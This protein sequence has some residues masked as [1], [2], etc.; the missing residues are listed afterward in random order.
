MTHTLPGRYH[1]LAHPL[2]TSPS[3]PRDSP[4]LLPAVFQRFQGGGSKPDT[5]FTD[6]GKGFSSPCTGWITAGY[7]QALKDHHLKAA[8]GDD[9]SLQPGKLQ[10]LMLHETS[11]AWIRHRLAK[12]V[13]AKAW[14]ESRDAYGA[15]LKR[16]VEEINTHHD[17]EGLC[18]S[19]LTRIGDLVDRKGGRLSQEAMD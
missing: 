16:V 19:F 6:R 7:K 11:V 4:S 17:V 5:V 9:V 8:M 14:E 1:R 2:P 10:E 12:S 13:P 3:L 15:R 18:R